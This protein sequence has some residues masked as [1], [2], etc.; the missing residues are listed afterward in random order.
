MARIMEC[1]SKFR[2]H[3]EISVVAKFRNLHHKNFATVVKFRNRLVAAC[4]EGSPY[5]TKMNS[6]VQVKKKIRT[7]ANFRMLP[8]FATCEISQNSQVAKF[9][10]LLHPLFVSLITFSSKL[11]FRRFLYYWKS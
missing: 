6:K 2:N 10:N 4:M 8:N 7:V 3:C 5:D 11:R 1:Q 9:S